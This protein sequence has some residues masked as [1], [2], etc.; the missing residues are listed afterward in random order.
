MLRPRFA[1]GVAEASS[2]PRCVCCSPLQAG[3]PL[4]CRAWFPQVDKLCAEAAEPAIAKGVEA[5]REPLAKARET[6]LSTPPTA[7]AG[8][9]AMLMAIGWFANGFLGISWA[10]WVL[11]V[12]IT[13]EGAVEGL[14]ARAVGHAHDE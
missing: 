3:G 9:V 1:A 11:A 13:A 12:A 5:L 2:W 4:W 10:V 7:L 8:G 14:M 6:V